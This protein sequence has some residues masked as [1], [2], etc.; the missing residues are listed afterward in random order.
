MAKDLHSKFHEQF[1]EL[2]LKLNKVEDKHNFSEQCFE[3]GVYVFDDIY[4]YLKDV[5][6]QE[7]IT[8]SDLMNRYRYDINIRRVLFKYLTYLEVSLKGYLINANKNKKSKVA[9][10]TFGQLKTHLDQHYPGEYEDMLDITNLRNKVFHHHLVTCQSNVFEGDEY[11]KLYKRLDEPHRNSMQKS[12]DF[13]KGK[14][15][16]TE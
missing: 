12:I 1:D 16:E 2:I 14:Y 7:Y 10:I 6:K 11:K 3:K 8:D 9:H 15:M 13:Y 5:E 4:E